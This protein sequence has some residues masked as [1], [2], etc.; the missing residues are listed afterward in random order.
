M[1]SFLFYLFFLIIYTERRPG[2][3]RRHLIADV[4]RDTSKKLPFFYFPSLLFLR[5]HALIFNAAIGY[6][7]IGE[8]LEGLEWL[9]VELIS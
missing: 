3:L 7:L 8:Q 9:I 5:L 2:A 1:I 4:N 6:A